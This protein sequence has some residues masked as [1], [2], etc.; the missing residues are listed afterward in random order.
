VDALDAAVGDHATAVEGLAVVDRELTGDAEEVGLV[1]ERVRELG[2]LEKSLGGDA[3][4][5]E[6]RP[7]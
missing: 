3:A 1:V 4:D 2:I 6:D 7:S 5:V